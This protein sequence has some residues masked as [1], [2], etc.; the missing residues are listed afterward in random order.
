MK[1]VKRGVPNI[2]TFYISR[3]S[4]PYHMMTVLA[5]HKVRKMDVKGGAEETHVFQMA[6]SRQGRG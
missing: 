6:S 4:A 3:T 1:Q 5:V 2:V